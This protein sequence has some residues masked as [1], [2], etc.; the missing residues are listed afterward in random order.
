MAQLS[1]NLINLTILA[2]IS[3]S[4]E[5]R[6]ENF[7]L[8]LSRKISL[9]RILKECKSN[10]F[11]DSKAKAIISVFLPTSSQTNKKSLVIRKRKKH[12]NKKCLMCTMISLTTSQKTMRKSNINPLKNNRNQK[13]SINNH[14]RHAKTKN[15]QIS[16]SSQLWSRRGIE[17]HLHAKID[18]DYNWYR[19]HI[20]SNIWYLNCRAIIMGVKPSV[21][22]CTI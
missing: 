7:M 3:I 22:M 13:W 1:S 11:K 21:R 14:K 6:P 9:L 20:Q 19:N 16:K 17:G 12:P 8:L 10:N 4:R 18:D 15:H 2:I 5:D